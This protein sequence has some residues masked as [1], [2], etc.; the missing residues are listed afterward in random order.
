M[1]KKYLSV[2]EVAERI[3]VTPQSVRI[4]LKSGKLR[5][6]RAG[7]LWRVTEEDLEKFLSG[8]TSHD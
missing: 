7:K 3:S 4:W 8:E 1:D 6:V 5:G 2:N